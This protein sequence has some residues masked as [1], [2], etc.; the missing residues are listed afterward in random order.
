MLVQLTLFGF[1]S[2]V[3]ILD[4]NFLAKNFVLI[5]LIV[6]FW[7]KTCFNF[8]NKN[9]YW[10]LLIIGVY[11]LWSLRHFL[12]FQKG[13]PQ[14]NILPRNNNPFYIKLAVVQVKIS[15]I[16]SI[17]LVW[18]LLTTGSQTKK[19]LFCHKK[20]LWNFKSHY[21]WLILQTHNVLSNL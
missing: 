7:E 18:N 9:L 1:I 20:I 17:F 13:Q 8:S 14:T 10:N 2:F 3:L 12:D 16:T 6:I 15:K 4:I 11:G 19:N 21:H 5:N